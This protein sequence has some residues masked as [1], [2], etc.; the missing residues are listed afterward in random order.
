LGTTTDD[1]KYGLSRT[2][3]IAE[4]AEMNTDLE[5]RP[6]LAEILHS[7]GQVAATTARV[8][9]PSEVQTHVESFV[10][11][12]SMAVLVASGLPQCQL[13]SPHK[14]IQSGFDKHG[15]LRLECL[16]SPTHCWDLNGHK[17]SC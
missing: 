2:T 7:I 15:N 10:R 12:S 3:T 13:A 4:D 1:G 5:L 17:A 6:E 9:A 14:P 8:R 16:H 11:M